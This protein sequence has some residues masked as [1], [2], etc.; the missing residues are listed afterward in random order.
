MQVEGDH[1]IEVDDLAAAALALGPEPRRVMLTSGRL[2]IPAF[3]A[4]P[5]HHYLIRAIDPPEQLALPRARVILDRGPFCENAERDLLRDENIEILVTKNSG[6][7]A[8]YGKIAAARSLRLPVVMVRPPKPL[9][10][11]TLHEPEEV[12]HF[13]ESHRP[14]SGIDRGV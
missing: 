4:A 8:T 11:K 9:G 1:W 13:I 14:K 3:E 2:G 12:I 7:A 6:G 10:G 5:Q